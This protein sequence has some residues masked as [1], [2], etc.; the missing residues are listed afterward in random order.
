MSRVH[1]DFVVCCVSV[2]LCVC[3][4]VCVCLS[5]WRLL[6]SFFLHTIPKTFPEISS[7][8]TIPRHFLISSFFPHTKPFPD[9]HFLIP[10]SLHTIPCHPIPLSRGV[11]GAREAEAERGAKSPKG[12][13]RGASSLREP[14]MLFVQF[15]PSRWRRSGA[16]SRAPL[17]HGLQIAASSCRIEAILTKN[18][19]NSLSSMTYSQNRQS[20][21]GKPEEQMHGLPSFPF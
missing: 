7:P 18:D 5:E 13:S 1:G 17:A 19:S 9:D 15:V 2:C 8:Y 4:S 21:S 10:P 20:S 16:V 14:F 6:D 11:A 12:A 3:L